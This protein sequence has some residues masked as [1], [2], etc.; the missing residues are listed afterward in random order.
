[1]GLASVASRGACPPLVINK[2]IGC[3]PSWLFCTKMATPPNL[4]Y[5]SISPLSVL[6][7]LLNSCDVAKSRNSDNTYYDNYY[8]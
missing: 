1:M 8:F 3:F 2:T 7:A 4:L 6:P 5:I